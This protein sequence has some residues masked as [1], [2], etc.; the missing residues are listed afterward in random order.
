MKSQCDF[1][2]RSELNWGVATGQ[3]LLE[4]KGSQKKRE[5]GKEGGKGEREREEREIRE[6]ER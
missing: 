4:V 1:T 6:R 3:V 2:K 5:R